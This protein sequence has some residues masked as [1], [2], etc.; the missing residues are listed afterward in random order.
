MRKKN[1]ESDDVESFDNSSVNSEEPQSKSFMIGGG[2]KLVNISLPGTS[3]VI[4]MLKSRGNRP[5]KSS[6]IA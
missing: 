4:K 3:T 5:I 6:Y 2:Q 1:K